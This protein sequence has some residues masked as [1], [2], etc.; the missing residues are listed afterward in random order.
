MTKKC[1]ARL[2]IPNQTF[3]RHSAVLG[4]PAVLLRKLIIG[5]QK[6]QAATPANKILNS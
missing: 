4:V 6:R 1:G 2:S 5:T 3:F